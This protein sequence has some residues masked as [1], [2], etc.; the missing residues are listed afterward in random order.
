KF[1]RSSRILMI[2]GGRE[3]GARPGCPGRR[4]DVGGFFYKLGRFV[5]HQSRK[6][7]WAFR[8]L[9]GTEA[10][11]VKAEYGVR[12]DLALAAG[13]QL[14]PAPD[15]AVARWLDEVGGALAAA[16]NQKERTFTLRPV[17]VPEPNAFA[18]PGGFIFV[19]RPLLRLCQGSHDDLAF[20][21]GHEM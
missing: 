16:V 4:R 14:E 9:T 8:S 20:V 19:T 3:P 2:Q 10:E 17:L 5:G 21:L 6:A 11:A 13:G 15:P 7:N 12:R 1:E 18:L